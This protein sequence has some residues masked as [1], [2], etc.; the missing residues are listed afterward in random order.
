MLKGGGLRNF[1]QR[2]ALLVYLDTVQDLRDQVPMQ[3][4]SVVGRLFLDNI[5]GSS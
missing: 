2:D 4:L 5:L 1:R 3:L